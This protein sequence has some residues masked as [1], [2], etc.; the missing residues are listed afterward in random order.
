[1]VLWAEVKYG[2][3]NMDYDGI[4]LQ[5][6]RGKDCRAVVLNLWAMAPKWLNYSLT[7][8]ASEHLHIR[9]LHYDA[10]SYKVA[11]KIVGWFGITT[12]RGTL[13]KGGAMREG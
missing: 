5:K 10:Q 13:L 8:H 6:I 2:Y 1:M 7:E 9:Y 4:S 12:T 3:E 11:V